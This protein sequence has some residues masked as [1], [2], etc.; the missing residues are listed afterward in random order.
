MRVIE[1]VICAFV[2]TVVLVLGTLLTLV[3]IVIAGVM[4][5]LLSP[6]MVFG[7]TLE[8]IR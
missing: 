5:L 1:G 2:A 3:S 4:F 8:V 6:I 7:W